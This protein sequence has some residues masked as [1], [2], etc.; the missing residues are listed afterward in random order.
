MHLLIFGVINLAAAALSGAAGGGG[1]LVS[2]PLLV[3][4]GLSPTAAIATSKFGGF[5]ISAGSSLR[6]MR[7][8]LT[9]RRPLI[10]F[11][12]VGA[13]AAFGGS[14]LL[15]GFHTN[16]R[17]LQDVMGVT[18]LVVGIPLLYVRNMGL[19]RKERSLPVRTAGFVL[20]FLGLVLQAAL[21]G[22]VGSLQ[23]IVLMGCFG[24]TAL[25]ANATRRVMQ[26]VVATISLAI[27]IAAGFVDF[28]YGAVG[29]VTSSIGGFLGAHLAIKKGNKFVINL[30]AVTSAILAL[31]LLWR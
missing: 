24:M 16:Q 23:L 13:V 30:F 28:R 14:M 8:R 9:E 7:E 27:F 29:L 31:Q 26:L 2:L 11:S 4:L 20:L 21:G 17:L 22:G 12:I 5:G 6:F 19:E 25:V 18:I 3:Q 10:I 1:G 15:V